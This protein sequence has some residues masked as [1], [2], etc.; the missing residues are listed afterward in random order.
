MQVNF[1]GKRQTIISAELTRASSSA[2]LPFVTVITSNPALL[3]KSLLGDRQNPQ[4][5]FRLALIPKAIHRG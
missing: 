4:N 1:C 3:E 2:F 5:R